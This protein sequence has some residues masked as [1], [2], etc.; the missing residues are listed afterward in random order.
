MES[1]SS[2]EEYNE[3]I[4]KT[5][6]NDD[7]NIDQNSDTEMERKYKKIFYKKKYVPCLKIF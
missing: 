5:Q 4:H 7:I 1:D 2:F 3:D 6:P